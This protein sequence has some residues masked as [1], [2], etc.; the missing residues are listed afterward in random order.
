MSSVIKPAFLRPI[1][2]TSS[3]NTFSVW[4]DPDGLGNDEHVI[5]LDTG[6]WANVFTLA[7]GIAAEITAADPNWTCTIEFAES[8]STLKM[9]VK[10]V[11][12]SEFG[13]TPEITWNELYDI[14]GAS[15]AAKGDEGLFHQGGGLYTGYNTY[16]PSHMWLPTYQSAEQGRFYVD[17][18]ELFKGNMSKT[19]FVSGNKTGSTIYW[20]DLNFVNELAENVFKSASTNSRLDNRTLEEF[21]EKCRVASP[22][23]SGNPSVKGFYFFPDW[24]TLQTDASNLTTGNGGINFDYS[25]GADTHVFCQMDVRGNPVPRASLPTTKT[26]YSTDF[27]IHTVDYSVSWTYYSA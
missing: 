19:G 8:S 18:G 4:L 21:A 27:Q 17:Q 24:N 3:N 2:I 13:T 5:N 9:Y 12:A 6:V 20:R 23:V 16:A 22:T 1:E 25:S 11:D 15:G 7:A 10:L 26:R 14:V